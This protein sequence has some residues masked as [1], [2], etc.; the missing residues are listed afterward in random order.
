[1]AVI[2]D[3]LSS[4]EDGWRRFNNNDPKIFYDLSYSNKAVS[5]YYNGDR[6]ATTTVGGVMKFRFFGT[7]FR[8]I[9]GTSTAET[10]IEVFVDGQSVGTYS[11]TSSG[12]EVRGVLHFEYTELSPDVHTVTV[13]NRTVGGAV[14]D[15]ID[16]DADG[17]LLL[18]EG[19]KL[20]NPD[21]GWKRYNN[22]YPSIDYVNGT[23]DWTYYT[24]QST[25]Y[26]GDTMGANK[27]KMS[28]FRFD[29]IGT[30]FLILITMF[31]EYSDAIRV[32][33]DG[34]EDEFFSAREN[35][36]GTTNF[37]NI[38]GCIREGLV[39]GRHTVEIQVTTSTTQY[40]YDYR[41]DAI[42]ID[43]DGRMLHPTEVT[44][45]K[46]LNVG[47]RIRCHYEA[48]QGSLGTISNFGKVSS[49]FIPPESSATPNGDFYLIMVE[50]WYRKKK[51][52]ADRNIQHSINWDELNSK[53]AVSGLPFLI[54]NEESA[55]PKMTTNELPSGEA[56]ASSSDGISFSPFKAFDGDVTTGWVS[57]RDNGIV[58]FPQWLSYSFPISKAISRYSLKAVAGSTSDMPL[59]W[60]LQAFNGTEW[61]N[62]DSRQGV[63]FGD[64]ETKYFTF[65]NKDSY[66]SYRLNITN[67]SGGEYIRIG[68]FAL[69]EIS[70]NSRL[71][72]IN[73]RLMTGGVDTT[74]VSE[75][76]R[77][78][79]NS[80]LNGTI[81]AGD[82]LV[83]NWHKGTSL[84][85]T[86]TASTSRRTRGLNSV[87][88]M[89]QV[90]TNY[91]GTQTGFRPLIEISPVI[92]DNYFLIKEGTLY[93]TYGDLGWETVGEN[94]TRFDFLNKGIIDLDVI[95][96]P[97]ELSVKPIEELQTSFDIVVY[98]DSTELESGLLNVKIDSVPQ[99]VVAENNIRLNNVE[100]IIAFN[101]YSEES[102]N[103]KIRYAVTFDNGD[104]WLS[105]NGTD[106]TSIGELTLENV[107][108]NGMSTEVINAIPS[109]KWND[110]L[111]VDRIV[112]FAYY[113]E[114]SSIEGNVAVDELT[115]LYDA[116]G[117][118]TSASH[119]SEYD[120]MY[121]ANTLMKVKLYA[122]GDYK[123]NYYKENPKPSEGE[124]V[125]WAEFDL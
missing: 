97:N 114:S 5:G 117:Y 84:T 88:Y 48:P 13:L 85:S 116:V 31:A 15:C 80:N 118:W 6:H 70:D 14:I 34:G 36:S 124:P 46:E 51:L 59:D 106:F 109:V 22:N 75:W 42:D 62:L 71:Y 107:R 44:E 1:M 52:I 65:F 50:D 21:L 45:I 37:D 113:L 61:V 57:G 94:P 81:I 10:A 101:M 32:R 30:K 64:D 74:D 87:T 103:G 100:N 4:P 104:N 92:F 102:I 28:M 76:D 72:D 123:I 26:S 93:K 120:Y 115:L 83:W 35:T 96:M 66:P 43:E 20:T 89:G 19:L 29:F 58:T 99:L 95:L 79:V 55:I 3:I 7:K 110:V 82:H 111:T 69:Y 25:E 56:N 11:R 53:G 49:E 78:I 27:G 73:I 39:Y 40:S 90:A 9:S 33:I 16:I 98:T 54:F 23:N 77:F 121:T 38:I 24:G 12:D 105:F 125:G 2:G 18:I 63:L 17:Y 86:V 8:I 47:N 119:G 108:D 60:S 67:N 91:V 41:L 122:D 68:E 112:K